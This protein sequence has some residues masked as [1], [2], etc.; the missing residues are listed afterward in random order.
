MKQQK[1]YLSLESCRIAPGEDR[2]TLVWSTGADLTRIKNK[3]RKKILLENVALDLTSR[4]LS[5]ALRFMF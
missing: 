1:N 5:H 2:E 3:P 4:S